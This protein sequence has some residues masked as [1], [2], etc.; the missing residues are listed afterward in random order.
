MFF[1]TIYYKIIFILYIII[2]FMLSVQR[3]VLI[4]MT[5]N[6]TA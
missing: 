6:T 1:K 4:V 5:N 3:K 2:Y